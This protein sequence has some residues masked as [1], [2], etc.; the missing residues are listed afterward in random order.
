MQPQQLVH[1]T[2]LATP[3]CMQT[4]YSLS[5]ACI[6]CKQQN[7]QTTEQSQIVHGYDCTLTNQLAKR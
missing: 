3:A 6:H 7:G 5:K 2:K 4:A 1:T